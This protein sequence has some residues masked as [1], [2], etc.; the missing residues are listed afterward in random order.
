ML[1]FG[2]LVTVKMMTAIAMMTRIDND[3]VPAL[4]MII[5]QLM[6]VV[7]K[8]EDDDVMAMTDDGRLDQSNID[9]VERDAAVLMT[10]VVGRRL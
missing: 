7:K 9:M 6:T 10:T 2:L 1:T 8:E 4:I 3:N 5:C